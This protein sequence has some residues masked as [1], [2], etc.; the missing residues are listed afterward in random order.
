MLAP[1]FEPASKLLAAPQQSG[2]AGAPPTHVE[3]GFGGGGGDE[4]YNDVM[5]RQADMIKYLQ[6]QKESLSLNIVQLTDRLRRYEQSALE[7]TEVR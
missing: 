4:Y 3:L 1:S 7:P 5:E 6:Q 2:G